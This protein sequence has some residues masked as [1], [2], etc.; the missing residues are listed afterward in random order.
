M[1]CNAVVTHHVCAHEQ[2]NCSPV[3][4][5]LSL[6]VVNL[7]SH[8]FL[9]LLVKFVFLKQIYFY[10]GAFTSS[11]A[12]F[13]GLDVCGVFAGIVEYTEI[14]CNWMLFNLPGFSIFKLWRLCIWFFYSF[15]SFT[16]YLYRSN[17]R[18]YIAHATRSGYVFVLHELH[19]SV[20]TNTLFANLQ[21]SFGLAITLFL[22]FFSFSSFSLFLSHSLPLSLT[23]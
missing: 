20:S 4:V 14:V 15:C 5:Q 9:Y 12:F 6:F 16:Q 11:L 13:L 19:V 23:F 3:H 8:F 21:F 1:Y 18:V 10:G 7:I 2:L 17:V 22:S